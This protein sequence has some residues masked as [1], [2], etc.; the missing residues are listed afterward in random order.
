VS[1]SG[2]E[3]KIFKERLSYSARLTL[4]RAFVNAVG[5]CVR[6]AGRLYDA[7][8]GVVELAEGHG[9]DLRRA[10]GV[11]A[12]RPTAADG[13]APR[14]FG[15]HDF[16]L[17]ADH[18]RGARADDDQTT[19][20]RRGAANDGQI[21]A[22]AHQP[23]GGGGIRASV[24]VTGGGGVESTFQCL[25]SLLAEIDRAET[26]V[27]VVDDASADET[28]RLL[29]HFAGPVRVVTNERRLGRAASRNRGAGLA[30]G[31]HLVFLDNAAE[32]RAGWLKSLA[33]T[34]DADEAVGAVGSLHVGRD[35]LVREAGAI[36]WR[37]G[38]ATRYGLGLSPE[39]RRLSFARE[40]DYCSGASLLVRRELFERLGGFDARFDSARYADADLCLGVR[41]LG[42]KVVFQ[43]FSRVVR[44]GG[45][46][47]GG[48]EG[49]GAEQPPAAG[50]EQFCAKWRAVLERDHFAR[51]EAAD[52]RAADRRRGPEVLVV[53]DLFP[54]PERDAGSARTVFMLGILARASRV[55]FVGLNKGAGRGRERELWRLGVETMGQADFL[56]EARRGRFRVAILS[57][58]EVAEALLP[59]LRRAD[60]RLRIV[61]DMVDAHFIR[62][63]REHGVTGEAGAAGEAARY[64]ELEARAARGS[65]AVWCASPDDA[66]AIAAVAP[67][68][69]VEVVPTIHEPRRGVPPFDERAGLLF[70]GNFRHRPNVD[71]VHFLM[72]EV[73]PHLRERLPDA[74]L[75]IAGPHAPAEVRSY[76]E[77]EGVQVLGFVPDLEPLHARARVFVAPLRFGAGV[78]GKIG[79]A[80]AQG[81][82]VVTTTVG[83]EGMGLEHRRQALI[84]DDPREMAA[85]IAELHADRELWRRL[86]EG[87]R[88]HVER[89]F[90]P[91]AVGETVERSIL[92][93]TAGLEKVSRGDS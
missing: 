70:V 67:G 26:E 75:A 47:A 18:L 89:V 66:R 79:E 40:A 90:A 36:V 43:P 11:R 76:A 91:R 59:A 37:D 34:A 86:S 53:N 10:W 85:R 74:P 41:S 3:K 92:R 45:A 48:V 15:A 28:P 23:P 24:I 64:R 61:F 46:A 81:L 49:A 17:L 60:P 78:K 51:G 72:R 83:A 82:P 20:D 55:V 31:R 12:G 52:E 71:A 35:G 13:F 39:D 32:V 38:E 62:L 8:A 88:E 80:L 65:D 9:L 42:R 63:G 29:S 33:Q 19:A 73:M 77:A 30:R 68:V 4:R 50:R 2:G 27:I 44:G 21:V 58:P 57:R 87:G 22:A 56:R 93:L 14:P 84:A 16:L 69:P 25:R 5:A 54:T 6:L 7:G 1:L